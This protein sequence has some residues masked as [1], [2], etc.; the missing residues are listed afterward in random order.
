MRYYGTALA[1]GFG[2]F[3]VLLIPSTTRGWILNGPGGAFAT[4][5]ALVISSLLTSYIF[6]RWIVSAS[7]FRDNLLRAVPIPYVGCVIYLTLY[8]VFAGS[9]DFANVGRVNVHDSVV[10][11]YWGLLYAALAAYVIIPYSF[12]CQWILNRISKDAA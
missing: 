2:W 6:K 9:I 1:L 10:L 11:Y 12:F 5:V 7:S 8:N 4:L 3:A